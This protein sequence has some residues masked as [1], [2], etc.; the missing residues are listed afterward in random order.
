MDSSHHN[1]IDSCQTIS[2]DTRVPRQYLT[3][4]LCIVLPIKYNHPSQSLHGERFSQ[5]CH[6]VD[7]TFQMR[8]LQVQYSATVGISILQCCDIGPTLIF[9]AK[10]DLFNNDESLAVCDKRG[11]GDGSASKWWILFSQDLIPH[12]LDHNISKRR[13]QSNDQALDFLNYRAKLN[14]TRRNYG[15][16]NKDSIKSCT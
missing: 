11:S 3:S 14:T 8:F 16:L 13:S 7:G 4:S 10:F 5:D 12:T 15:R 2:I 6:W 1:P 9:P